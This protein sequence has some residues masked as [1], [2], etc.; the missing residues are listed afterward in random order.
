MAKNIDKVG[1]LVK[2]KEDIRSKKK[3]KLYFL[4]IKKL[5]NKIIY[6]TK[7]HFIFGL[8]NKFLLIK[9]KSSIL[10][11]LKTKI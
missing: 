6:K 9:N 5:S 7:W 4:N 8:I 3:L 10:L 1:K 2:K 11:Y